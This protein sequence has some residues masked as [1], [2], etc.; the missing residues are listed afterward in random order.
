MKQQTTKSLNGG[1]TLAE[2]VIALGILV[3]LI[4]GFLAVFGPAATVIRKTLSADE[5]SRLQATLER[6][7]TNVREGPE[8]QRYQ[9]NPFYKAMNW[10][11][12]S[13]E[14][15]K[16]ILVYKYRGNPA[17]SRQDG[18]LVPADT[19]K[20]ELAGLDFIVQPMVRR[21]DDPLLQE[22]L[23]AVDGRV[24]FV[25]MTQLVFEGEGLR[26]SEDI[27]IVTDPHSPG[28]DFSTNPAKY[29]EAVVAY[30][31]EFYT[32]PT[33]SYDYLTKAFDPEKFRKP[34]FTRNL[35]VRR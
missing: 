23:E 20:I 21:V 22:D 16:T 19:D 6:E 28:E 27:G 29:P 14:K 2:S 34:V 10:I 4:T 24:F 11:A 9:N 18:T 32:L 31:A 26:L 25:K 35:S 1:F 12:G 17:Q 5:A 30:E 7:L 15:G 3:V 8:E 13:H 33:K